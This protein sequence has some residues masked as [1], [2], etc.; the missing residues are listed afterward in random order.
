[1]IEYLSKKRI[2]TD[3]PFNK[4]S[5]VYNNY[6]NW[7]KL[8]GKDL[9]LPGFFLT[10]NQM[11]WLSFAHVAYLKHHD[12]NTKRSF[13]LFREYFNILLKTIP[14]FREAFMCSEI[15]EDE[16]NI[17]WEFSIKLSQHYRQQMQD[18][19]FLKEKLIPID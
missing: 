1:M 18:D 17:Q 14:D 4:L 5:L 13:E 12:I 7:E 16:E 2:F 8:G 6:L 3:F 19:L 9:Q 15:T 10:N 11:F